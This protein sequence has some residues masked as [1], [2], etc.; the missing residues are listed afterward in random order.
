MT[1]SHGIA[2]A[3]LLSVG[4]NLVVAGAFLGR[5]SRQGEPVPPPM[6]WAAREL[7][8][9]QRGAVRAAL[10][11]RLPAV[12]P[13]RRALRES[14][15]TIR[16]LATAEE[17]DPEA[18]K[19]ALARQRAAQSAYQALMHEAAV[20]VAATLPREQ[21]MALLGRALQREV[22]QHRRRPSGR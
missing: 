3:L 16:R 20:E 6:D 13:Q 7:P 18:M 1:R 4:V 15:Q 8:A 22:P 12:Q 2:L 17:F 14:M 10:R 19:A 11:E 9:E 5:L 21:R